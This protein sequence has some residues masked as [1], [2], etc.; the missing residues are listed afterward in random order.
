MSTFAEKILASRAG[1]TSV[2]AGD[3]VTVEP[4]HLLTHDNTSAIMGK[5]KKDLDIYGVIRPD[6]NI[7][8]IDHVSPASSSKIAAGHKEVREFV[9][10]YGIKY[11][12]D[13]GVG[14]C[15]QVVVEKGHAKP[16]GLIVGSDSHT[17]MYGALNCFSTGIDRTEA[18]A[19]TLT[20][21]LWL[22]VPETIKITLRGSFQPGVYAKDLVL[23]IIGDI[24][25]GGANYKYVEFHGAEG[26]SV[27]ERFTISNMAI[28]MGAKGGVFPCDASTLDYLE[29]TAGLDRSEIPE[30]IWADEGAKYCME[31]EYDLSTI[32]PTVAKPHT[33]DNKATVLEVQGVPI[34][35]CFL[36]TCTNGRSDDLEIAAE[37]V[38]GKKVKEG[39]RFL[40]APASR[41][42]L[43]DA[44]RSGAVETLLDA[45]AVIL[46]PGCAACLGAH[47]GVLAPGEVCL[48]TANRNFKGR[49]GEKNSEIYLASPA[50][51]A[52]SALTGVITDPRE[53]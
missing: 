52:K 46:P 16:G 49:M 20:G 30:G 4:D 45:G 39:V 28:E 33:V 6:L 36:G 9:R 1:L 23:S 35:Q 48:S 53:P 42:T 38:K 3:I 15:H 47:L 51:V 40:I 32:V 11:F 14:V 2:V 22:K 13:V 24:G 50:T 7:I 18:A 12:Y 34:D 10:K 27:S 37:I 41:E 43:R 5:I 19:L 26:L 31:L 29:N 21:Q 25:A 8:V 17:C 44:L